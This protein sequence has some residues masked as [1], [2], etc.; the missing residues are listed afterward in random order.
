[1]V[2]EFRGRHDGLMLAEVELD[3]PTAAFERPAWLGDEV[4]GDPQYYNSSLA[5][6]PSGEKSS[7]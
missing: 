2:D 3:S 1:M 5:A 7:P 6:L 4:T